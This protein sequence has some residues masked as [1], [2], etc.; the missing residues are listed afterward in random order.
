MNNVRL[1]IKSEILQLVRIWVIACTLL[2]RYVW[3]K[4]FPED[5]GESCELVKFGKSGMSLQLEDLKSTFWRGKM[6]SL[7]VL[8][9]LKVLLAAR[10]CYCQVA[11]DKV[12]LG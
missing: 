5:E 11:P 2:R 1:Q 4:V 8:A 9:S 6:V 10:T 12:G 3:W 7:Q